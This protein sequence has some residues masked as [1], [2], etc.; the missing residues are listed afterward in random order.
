VDGAD[1]AQKRIIVLGRVRPQRVARAEHEH[2]YEY[3]YEYEHEGRGGRGAD[4]RERGAKAIWNSE[5]ELGGAELETVRPVEL[6]SCVKS[7]LRLQIVG[8]AGEGDS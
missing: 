6:P 1:G 4:G 3:E 8:G 7:I 5:I 2:A